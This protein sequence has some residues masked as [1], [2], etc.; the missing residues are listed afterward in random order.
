MTFVQSPAFTSPPPP[1]AL[2][3]DCSPEQINRLSPA[4]LAHIGDVI[5]ELYVRLHCL[6]PPQRLQAYHNKVVAQ[7]R[8][9][10]Q[11]AYLLVLTPHLTPE[12]L[13]VVRRGR[14]AATG[15]SRRL[16]VE[17]Y[18][19]A[20][21]LEALVGYLYLTDRPRLEVLLALLPLS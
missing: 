3:L 9:E 5:Y 12:E 21:G 18:Q 17:L 11:A 16:N 13:D 1:S 19:Q 6:F 15:R 20:S 8:A 2:T 10:Q 7:V 4:L 14:N